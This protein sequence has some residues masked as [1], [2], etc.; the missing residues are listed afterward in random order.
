[1]WSRNFQGAWLMQHTSCVDSY[2]VLGPLSQHAALKARYL[3]SGAALAHDDSAERVSCRDAGDVWTGAYGDARVLKAYRAAT[4]SVACSRSEG[5]GSYHVLYTRALHFPIP[6]A[7]FRA[8]RWRRL[9]CSWRQGRCMSALR[10][11]VRATFLKH[12]R[13]RHPHVGA[14]AKSWRSR[15]TMASGEGVGCQCGL[16]SKP[17]HS[18]ELLFHTHPQHGGCV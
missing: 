5:L 15:R 2:L 12:L 11:L 13:S 18:H 16:E 3:A 9:H 7:T 10:K 14:V 1:M 17:I 4:L 8:S 6:H